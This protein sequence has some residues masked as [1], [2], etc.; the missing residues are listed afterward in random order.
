M[1]SDATQTGSLEISAAA[2]VGR[3]VPLGPVS[4][5]PAGNTLGLPRRFDAAKGQ[6]RPNIIFAINTGHFHPVAVGVVLAQPPAPFDQRGGLV[7]EYHGQR[8]RQMQ[9]CTSSR[10]LAKIGPWTYHSNRK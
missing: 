1:F 9:G 2:V 10:T 6:G 8:D 3:Q 5:K 7:N 4:S